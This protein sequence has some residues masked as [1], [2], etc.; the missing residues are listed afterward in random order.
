M[1]AM[2]ATSG[3]DVG[4]CER[5]DELLMERPVGRL[6]EIGGAAF[7]HRANCAQQPLLLGSRRVG[8]KCPSSQEDNVPCAMDG[9]ALGDPRL[10]TS[11]RGRDGADLPTKPIRMSRLRARRPGRRHGRLLAPRMS[12]GARAARGLSTTGRAPAAPLPRG[13]PPNRTRRPPLLLGN[14]STFVS[15]A[16]L[17]EHHYDP[18]RLCA[19]GAARHHVQSPGRLSGPSPR[20]RCRSS[21]LMPRA[22]HKLTTRPRHRDAAAFDWRNV[23]APRRINV[24]ALPYKAAVINPRR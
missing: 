11:R 18:S 4:D 5:H 2:R 7:M 1:P 15:A 14:T 10:R 12:A 3:L 22:N 17:Q 9:F 6:C 20:S 8:I 21:S 13:P 19:G 23:Q 16:D 24:V